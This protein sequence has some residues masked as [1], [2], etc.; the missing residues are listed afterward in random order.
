MLRKMKKIMPDGKEYIYFVIETT[1]QEEAKDL[2]NY[3]FFVIGNHSKI[4]L[5]G[6]GKQY[7]FADI[8]ENLNNKIEIAYYADSCRTGRIKGKKYFVLEEIT[9]D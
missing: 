7:G 8:Q 1:N 5:K 3:K 2:T 9:N 6:F 4:T